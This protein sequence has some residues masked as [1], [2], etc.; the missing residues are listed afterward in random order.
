MVAEKKKDCRL[1]PGGPNAVY[2]VQ[3]TYGG[4]YGRET[5]VARQAAAHLRGATGIVLDAT[6]S[7]KAFAYALG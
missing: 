2:V 3:Q 7:A 1:F 5:A 4:A 6:Y